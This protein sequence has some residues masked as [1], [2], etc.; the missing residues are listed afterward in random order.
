M[1]TLSFVA[2]G[3]LVS[4][5]P[6]SAVAAPLPKVGL[7][8]PKA[9]AS[10][11]RQWVL[12][13]R[14][15][16]LLDGKQGIRAIADRTVTMWPAVRTAVAPHVP[17]MLDLWY[18]SNKKEVA[19]ADVRGAA[20][21][22]DEAFD[23]VA[24]LGFMYFLTAEQKYADT[25]YDIL[26]LAGQTPRWGWFNWDGANMP[27]IHYGQIT[28][29]AAFC[30]DFCWDGWNEAQQRRAVEIVAE[31][32]VESYW[33]L[34]SLAPFMALHHLRAKNQ[35]NNALSAALIASLVV[36]ESVPENRVWLDSLLQTY[37][38]V[39]AHD[40]GWAGTNL[41]SGIDGY[42]NVSMQNL[43]TAAVA[44][45]NARGIDLRVHPSF[46]EAAWYPIMHEATVGRPQGGAFN[47]PYPKSD[48][49]LWGMI[50]HKPI[51]LPL[52]PGG[53][54]WW[55]DFAGQFPESPAAYFTARTA[56]RK[57]GAG[58]QRGHAE[59]LNLLWVA[60]T[61]PAADPPQPSLLF[62]ATDR[63]AMFRSGYGSPHAFLSFNGDLFL[64]AR[65]EVLGCTSGLAWHYPWHQYAVTE[66]VL[67]TEGLPFSPSMVIYESF[68][69]PV[70]SL[71]RS[72][73]GES[74][75]KYYRRPQQARSQLDYRERTRDILYVRSDRRDETHD[76]FVFVDRVRHDEPKWHSFNWHIWNQ[77]GNEGR[78]ERV[79]DRSVLAR[80]PNASLLL[81]TLSHERMSYEEQAIPS[82]PPVSYVFDHNARL[83]RAIAGASKPADAQPVVLSAKLW[84]DAEPVQLDG[85][86]A[87]LVT[88]PLAKSPKFRAP[89]QL[90]AGGRYQVQLA[91][92]KEAARIYENF[93][94]TIDLK[95][96]DAAGN[97]LAD[98]RD[99]VEHRAPDALRLTDPAS[100][101]A[102]YREWRTTATH[103]T[104]PAGVA[105]VEAT[106]RPA[107]Y[108]H[109]TKLT[110]ESKFW[111]SDLTIQ[112]LGVPERKTDDLLVT[113]VMPLE[114]SMSPPEYRSQRL[115]DRIEAEIV[116]PSGARDRLNITR[117]GQIECERRNGAQRWAF[118]AGVTQLAVGGFQ[119][120]SPVTAALLERD[121]RVIG[122]LA[123][124]SSTRVTLAGESRTVESGIHFY[125][126]QIKPNLAAE[127]L[128]TNSAISQERLR[129]ALKSLADSAVA[130]RDRY[131]RQGWQ[132]VA[133]DAI[134]VSASATRDP[135]FDARNLI[136]NKSW[137]MPFDGVVDYTLGDLLTMGN[138]GYG[139]DAASYE[140]DLVS[141]PLYFRPT[142]W[143]L[144][145]RQT[146]DVVIRLKKP[147]AVRMVRL[148]NTTNAGLND[149]ATTDARVEL[150]G[151]DSDEVLWS[152]PIQFGK[153]WD[154][155][156]KS[157]FVRPDF[158]ASYGDSFRGL[159]EPGVR[160]PFGEGWVDVPI[161]CKQPAARVRIRID[162]YWA[163]GGG[164]NEVQVYAR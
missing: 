99:A 55:Y 153:P 43:Y 93:P 84:S 19:S 53:G 11:T 12:S 142:Y 31:K 129:T 83:L 75:V 140:Q 147:T 100:N 72:R 39:I 57:L 78:Y 117:Q 136:D 71:I 159:L 149:F 65:N 135:R 17:K 98:T 122:D 58:H 164:L 6:S 125:D 163:G 120:Q 157:A 42:W 36:G 47:K 109:A 154:R 143:L 34:V 16:Q 95:L 94:W 49:G 85:R 119:S 64:S 33:R 30:V 37:S 26:E 76:Y 82:Q 106:L 160:V 108:G 114:N 127:S 46:A 27:Q 3:L 92:Q 38:W 25:A 4:W 44:L 111:I 107:Q 124:A 56:G 115:G 138:G 162:K 113:L 29:T 155:V 134:D 61:R 132:N 63:E 7:L 152:Q 90:A 146:G 104:A 91:A 144:P 54:A 21:Q 151:A 112:P 52:Q 80:R 103:F 2:I 131:V 89:L 5:L 20:E 68:D 1:R 59:I 79:D 87:A 156:F 141:W 77:S 35:G 148:M 10:E 69:S 139:R 133:L 28:R 137:E 51:E 150:L 116:H 22:L 24:F 101:E 23:A 74:N 60:R 41:E 70:A 128:R 8:V 18:Q 45:N 81:A 161:D 86:D 88:D 13:L 97:V 9:R 40:I 96:L 73:S 32:G 118:G 105:A 14:D 110:P 123:A 50:E 145:L 102:T 126:G 130:D 158:F 66:S 15:T 48:V 121:G 67:E 62:K